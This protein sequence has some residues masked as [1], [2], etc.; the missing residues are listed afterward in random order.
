MAKNSYNKTSRSY[1]GRYNKKRKY[2]NYKSKKE[3]TTL[4]KVM[5]VAGN[6]LKMANFVRSIVNVE[7]KWNDTIVIPTRISWLGY[8]LP[9][10]QAINL[11]TGPND[12]NGDS[13][14]YTSLQVKYTITAGD[15]SGNP[16]GTIVRFIIVQGQKEN[17]ETPQLDD[18][19]DVTGSPALV[20]SL[21]KISTDQNWKIVYDK[22]YVVVNDTE[23][24]LVTEDLYLEFDHHC[25][26]V[27][28]D[29]TAADGGLYM[30][31]MSDKD[32]SSDNERPE[33]TC[34]TRLRYIDN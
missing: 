25:K 1:K 11:G 29:Q 7:Y 2:N 10:M 4:D 28:G 31:V 18:I 20:N 33:F 26:Y 8:R 15:F 32:P 23:R 12:R 17:D 34:S 24:E 27:T 22:K 14:K 9:I 6:A 21:R 16:T 3:P 30:F 13:I 19:Y 5:N